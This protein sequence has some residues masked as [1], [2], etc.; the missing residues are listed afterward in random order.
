MNFITLVMAYYENKGQLQRQYELIRSLPSE[1]KHY[2]KVIIVDD[3]S[4]KNPAFKFKTGTAVEVFRIL[5]PKVQWNQDAARNIGVHNAITPWV[6]LTDIDHMVPMSTWEVLIFHGWNENSIYKFKRMSATTDNGLTPYKPH[7]NTWFMTKAMYDRAGGYDER[8]AGYYGT[9]WDIRDRLKSVGEIVEMEN[10]I[11]RVGREV[12]PDA[13]TTQFPRKTPES[14]EAIKR[15]KQE[16]GAIPGWRPVTM[17]FP[18]ER[19][20]A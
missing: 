13:S 3:C 8:F 7:P 14:G 5:P 16:R 9:D 4:E 6:F 17:T 1:F 12:V 10:H 20:T 11:I 18:Y 19:V 2:I 15:I